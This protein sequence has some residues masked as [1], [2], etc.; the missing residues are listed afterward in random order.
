MTSSQQTRSRT[1]TIKTG[2]TTKTVRVSGSSYNIPSVALQAG[3]NTVQIQDPSGALTSIKVTLSTASNYYSGQTA[4]LQGAATLSKC[5]DANGCKPTNYKVGN[6]SPTSTL[7]FSGISGGTV[8]GSKFV[9]LDYINYDLAFGSSWTGLGTNI[10][11]A[12]FAVNDGK[13][14]MWSFPISG[15]DWQDTGRM[16]VLLEGFKAGSSNK[17]VVGAPGWEYGPDIVGLDVLS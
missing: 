12:S 4:Q 13:A 8:A 16:G 11:N 10:R 2:T 17:I 15:G 5:A 7:T 14:K 3:Q 9:Y 1:V 6:L